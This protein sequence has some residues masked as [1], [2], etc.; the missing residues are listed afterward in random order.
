[1]I[2]REAMVWVQVF[3][4]SGPRWFNDRATGKQ[5]EGADW[6]NYNRSLTQRFAYSAPWLQTLMK[7]ARG[8]THSLHMHSSSHAHRKRTSRVNR[9]RPAQVQPSLINADHHAV[10][11]MSSTTAALRPAATVFSLR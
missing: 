4:D 11:D 6:T 8:G 10:V 1:L 3:K 7:D 9:S 2:H 5:S